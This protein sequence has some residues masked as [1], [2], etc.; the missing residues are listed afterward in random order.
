MEYVITL[1]AVFVTG[2]LVG[3]GIST[4]L[5]AQT[6][7]ELHEE[8]EKLKAEKRKKPYITPQIIEISDPGTANG[9]DFPG[10]TKIN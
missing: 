9:V 7:Y 5:N 1:I 3:F 2:A 10:A 6:V 4:V 8:I